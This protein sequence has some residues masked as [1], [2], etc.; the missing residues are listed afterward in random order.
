MRPEDT[1]YKLIELYN[2]KRFSEVLQYVFEPIFPGEKFLENLFNKEGRI[3]KIELLKVQVEDQ[4]CIMEYKM[5]NKAGWSEGN[6]LL[7]REG[8]TWL[9]VTKGSDKQWLAD[10]GRKCAIDYANKMRKL[11][12]CA[13]VSSYKLEEGKIDNFFNQIAKNYPIILFG[14]GAHH[15]QE[16]YDILINCI[17]FLNK[18]GYRDILVEFPHSFSWFYNKYLQTGD[19]HYYRIIGDEGDFFKRLYEINKNLPTSKKIKVWGIDVDHLNYA[20]VYQIEEYIKKISD[21][22]LEERV[23]TSLSPFWMQNKELNINIMKTLE[24]IFEEY[25]EIL[26]EKTSNRDFRRIYQLMKYNE[27]SAAVFKDD[28]NKLR[29]EFLQRKFVDIYTELSKGKR[30][31]I[32]GVFGNWHTAKV[33]FSWDCNFQKLGEYLNKRYKN[34]I[35]SIDMLPIEGE[36]YESVHSNV[37][38]KI[39]IPKGS[40]EEILAKNIKITPVLIDITT[41]KDYCFYDRAGYFVS[42]ETYDSVILYKSSLPKRI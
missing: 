1:V 25:K 26:I 32:I 9:V 8:Q 23:L 21:I 12:Q 10:F 6:L 22:Q 16:S 41:L 39:N 36:F 37:V 27:L 15:S 42:P 11:I 24:S 4:I 20:F 18:F 30:K 38:R 13:K 17:K 29:E 3:E 31:K 7:I 35:Y 5:K 14:V 33:S 19:F 40:I 34:K 2:E 28:Y